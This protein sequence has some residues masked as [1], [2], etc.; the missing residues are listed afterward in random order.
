MKRN[1]S[2][3]DEDI[4]RDVT[5]GLETALTQEAKREVKRVHVRVSDA[6]VRLMGE[7]AS[8]EEREAIEK[9]VRET[10]GVRAVDNELRIE[11]R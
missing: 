4:R 6:N 1:Q 5:R 8:W 10:P 3:S 7:V 9:G 2:M 11:E